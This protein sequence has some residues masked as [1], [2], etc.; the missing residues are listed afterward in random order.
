MKIFRLF[1]LA[2][3][4]S[5]FVA[6]APA[7]AQNSPDGQ[8]G[9]GA[10][11]GYNFPGL[12]LSYAITPAFHLGTQFSVNLKNTTVSGTTSNAQKIVIAP[13]GRFIFMGTPMFKPFI[14]GQ[15]TYTSTTE[16]VALGSST[17]VT[18]SQTG[19]IGF[20]GAEYF[21]S[22]NLGIHGEIGI[23]SFNLSK[24]NGV[25]ETNFGFGNSQIGV[26]WFF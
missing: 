3:F 17:T 7:K 25:D 19:F 12:S 2:A 23:I 18:T 10:V 13:Y 9:V 4:A 6:L 14:Q 21:V 20:L 8:F 5:I 15:V 24:N 16:P 1:S 26:E 11:V 22:R